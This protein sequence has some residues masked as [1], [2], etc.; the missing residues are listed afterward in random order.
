[1]KP[2]SFTEIFSTDDCHEF[3]KIKGSQR[4]QVNSILTAISVTIVAILINSTTLQKSSNWVL[5]QLSAS[6]PLLVTSSLFYTKTSYRSKKEYPYWNTAASLSH[7][8]G[9]FAIINSMTLIMFFRGYKLS[10]YVLIVSII[11]LII[12][13]SL[14]DYFLNKKRLFEKLVKFVIY[15]AIIFFGTLPLLRAI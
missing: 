14:M 9:Y 2:L 13:Y 3:A 4:I 1:M 15:V 8:L 7:S 10:A 11:I 5:F 12:V 6:I